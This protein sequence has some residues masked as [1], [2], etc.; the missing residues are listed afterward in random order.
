MMNILD[1]S[2]RV[3]PN[4]KLTPVQVVIL[5][6]IY[7][8]PLDDTEFDITIYMRSS[9]VK[10]RFTQRQYVQWLY[11]TFRANVDLSAQEPKEYKESFLAIGRRSGKSL[12]SALIAL[13][14]AY[15]LLQI[16]DPHAYYNISPSNPINITM[17]GTCK[18]QASL[19]LSEVNGLLAATLPLVDNFP[20]TATRSFIKFGEFSEKGK[21]CIHTKSSAA[22]SIRGMGM[23]TVIMD[24][25]AH[26]SDNGVPSGG[27]VYTAALPAVAGYAPWDHKKKKTTGPSDGKIVAMSSPLFGSYFHER[28]ES[29]RED[30]HSLFMQIPTW[31]MMPD[32]TPSELSEYRSKYGE[33]VFL[34][35]FGAE[36]LDTR[37]KPKSPCPLCGH[38]P[39]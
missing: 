16:G 21:V 5:K 33:K 7:G 13:Y 29:M 15:V 12:M 37:P 39:D 4:L 8:I 19:L 38:K 28:F 11:L 6:A 22:R 27:E 34:V 9:W 30:K 17:F 3:I 25:I 1:F 23:I 2:A 31:E 14:D 24:E 10:Q 20:V 36:F 26:Y 35:E 32:I 18:D